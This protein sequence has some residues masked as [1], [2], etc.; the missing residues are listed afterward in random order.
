MKTNQLLKSS[1]TLVT[2]AILAA[3]TA[4]TVRQGEVTKSARPTAPKDILQF[5]SGGHVLGFAKSGVYLAS[6]SH[7]LRVQFV[8]AHSTTPLSTTSPSETGNTKAAAPLSQVTYPN[9]WDGVTLTYDAPSGAVARSTYRLDPYAK[10]DNIRLRYNAPV[11]VQGDGSLRVNFKTG[12]LN[13]S[14]PQAWQER[15]GKRVPV[16]IAFAPRGKDEI[17]F[18]TGHYDRSQPLFIDPTL[19]WNTFL[20][21]SRVTGLTFSSHLES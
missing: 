21:G 3:V 17:T 19:T 4:F 11:A 2:I 12:T 13:E 20:G 15:S 16:Q 7:A 8:N 14:A 18:T 6:G 9:L 5:T 10:T 1:L